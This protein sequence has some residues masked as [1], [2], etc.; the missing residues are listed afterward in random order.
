LIAIGGL[1]FSIADLD[2]RINAACPDLRVAMI[3]DPLLGTRLA[4][5]AE[6]PEKAA[7]ALLDAG[8]PRIIA[9]AVLQS[10]SVRAT[11]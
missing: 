9:S 5:W 6:D 8:L 1:R 7:L 11:G 2:R 3:E 4:I 10:E